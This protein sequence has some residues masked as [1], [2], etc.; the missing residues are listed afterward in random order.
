MTQDQV[1]DALARE[2]IL[3]R[4]GDLDDLQTARWYLR[5]ALEI[6]ISHFTKDMEEIVVLTRDGEEI[7]RYKGVTDCSVKMG[8]R[9]GDISSVLN[10]TQRTAGGFRFV[11][12]KDYAPPGEDPEPEMELF[13]LNV[14]N[15]YHEKTAKKTTK[16]IAVTKESVTFTETETETQTTPKTTKK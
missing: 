5:Q 7:Q 2:W 4:G 14:N 11:K 10:G 16:K 3:T 6:G 13:R 15:E 1:I 9:Q 8:I 12:A